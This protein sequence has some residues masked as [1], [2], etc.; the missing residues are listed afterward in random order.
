MAIKNFTY[1]RTW[2]SSCNNVK[3]AMVRCDLNIPSDVEDLSRITAVKDTVQALIQLGLKVVLI[4]HYKRPA[5]EDYFTSKFSLKQIV[6]K[7]QKVMGM[8][9]KF[10]PERIEHLTKNDIEAQL[11]L[12]EN[13]RFYPGEKKNDTYFAQELA[14]L[15]DVYIN[16][17]FSVA[18]RLHASVDAI[19]KYLSS[20]SGLAFDREIEGI[21]KATSNISR[22]YTAIIGGAKVSS[23]IEVLREISKKADTLI[24]AGAMANTFFAAQGME[25][26]NSLI[27]PDF[28]ETSLEILKQSKARI[29]LPSDFIVSKN[30]NTPGMPC[31]L[32]DIK[33]DV[34][35][36]DIG[37]KTILSIKN[38]LK[39]SKT[40]LWNGALGA[41]EFS[42]FNISSN[43]I[44]EYAALQ[45]ENDSLISIIGGG[46]TAAS[47][48][49]FKNKM[50]FVSTAGGAFLEY[51][52]GYNL[53]GIEALSL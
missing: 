13:L 40:L 16:D 52:A 27:E 38:I 48:G 32:S 18:H 9:L 30:I 8:P 49:E 41:F 51:I 4:S 7:I 33:E 47:I 5:P 24:I 44:A 37:P 21:S 10:I 25:F 2:L 39:Q 17:A 34:S 53:P 6:D 43:E 14:K 19:T 11:T 29:I 26:G 20:F 3:I 50:T 15:A 22:P 31:L 36:F 45:T 1:F 42:N 46:E 35:C 12:L 28:F 23:K